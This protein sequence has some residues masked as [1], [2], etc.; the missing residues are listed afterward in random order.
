MLSQINEVKG[1]IKGLKEDL[2]NRRNLIARDL[3]PSAAR[4]LRRAGQTGSSACWHPDFAI[5][6]LGRHAFRD[7]AMAFGGAASDSRLIAK[8]RDFRLNHEGHDPARP[9]GRRR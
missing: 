6:D 4:P 9:P 5:G 1:R 8:P 3:P 2:A 7:R